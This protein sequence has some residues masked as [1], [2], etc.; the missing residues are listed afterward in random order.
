MIRIHDGLRDAGVESRIHSVE[1]IEGS[2]PHAFDIPRIRP[3]RFAKLLANFQRQPSGLPQRIR[4]ARRA[5]ASCEV[6]SPPLAMSPYDLSR[7]NRDVDV[8]HLHWVGGYFDFRDFFASINVPVVWTL[9][10]QNPYF[11]G[12]HYQGDLDAATALLPLEYELR[13]IKKRALADVNL[14]VAGNSVWNSRLAL[15]T[16]VLPRNTLVETIYLPLPSTDY[17]PID[18]TAAKSK[19][20]L[21]PSRFVV[22]FA[23]AAL[24]NRRKGFFDMIA[25]VK[26]LPERI[27]ENTT[28]LS[29]G[30]EPDE[31]TRQ[32]V[33]I[34]WKHLGHQTPGPE[35]SI[36]YSAMDT[37]VI[38]SLEEA[39][40][41]TPLEALACETAVVATDVGGIPETVHHERTGLLVPRRSPYKIAEALVRMHDDVDLRNSC[42][43]RGR[44]LA[45]ERH[46]PGKIASQYVDLYR[47]LIERHAGRVDTRLRAAT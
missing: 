42:A 31:S 7:I 44:E 10:D 20:T 30:R 22:G 12:F 13:N 34:D 8:L 37:F 38:S 43:R 28:L 2:M 46:A 41:Q 23:C 40:G 16:D 4:S 27:R 29:F 11:G 25:A 47:Q 18:K 21:E 17:T 6:F 24:E 14:A 32:A 19:L 39:F 3:S 35:Q 5:N 15:T 36:A 9:H 26:H 33:D 1:S 45:M